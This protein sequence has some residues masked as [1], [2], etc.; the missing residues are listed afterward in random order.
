MKRRES[1]EFWGALLAQLADYQGTQATFC[2]QQG[3]S[4]SSLRYHL[5]QM[6]KKV[7]GGNV[8]TD[9][10][11]V[12]VGKLADHRALGNSSVTV[13]VELNIGPIVLK[14]WPES[15]RG[16]LTTALR[17]AMEACGRT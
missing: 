3:V 4:V 1:T 12:S 5:G 16:A 8:G 10:E 17:A 6:S 9:G 7:T 11:F 15:D 13:A 2:R 14:V